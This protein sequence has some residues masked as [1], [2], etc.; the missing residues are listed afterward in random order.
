VK[1][2]LI[3]AVVLGTIA[4]LVDGWLDWQLL[5]QDG[6]ILLRLD[7][8]EHQPHTLEFGD[9]YRPVGVPNGS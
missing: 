1:L 3:A 5:R 6:R 2:I 8:L 4:L 7:E 9:T